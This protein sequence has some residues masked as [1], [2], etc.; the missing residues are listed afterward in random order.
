MG[1]TF[2][3]IRRRASQAA[4]SARPRDAGRACVWR[5]S[6][7]PNTNVCLRCDLLEYFSDEQAS[8]CLRGAHGASGGRVL[9]ESAAFTRTGRSRTRSLPSACDRRC[10]VGGQRHG[11]GMALRPAANVGWGLHVMT[12]GGVCPGLGRFHQ[13]LLRRSNDDLTD[14]ENSEHTAGRLV[15][16]L[17][18]KA[19]GS[20]RLVGGQRRFDS[21]RPPPVGPGRRR[22]RGHGCRGEAACSLQPSKQFACR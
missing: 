20:R 5:R 15:G 22:G 8:G 7:R 3:D 14:Q 19:K 18:G 12:V 11:A 21:G 10:P 17:A 1:A 16:K 6:T 4:T 2:L 13:D 9:T